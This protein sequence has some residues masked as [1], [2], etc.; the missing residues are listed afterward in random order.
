MTAGK[1][2]HLSCLS[3]GVGEEQRKYSHFGHNKIN[4]YLEP[5]DYFNWVEKSKKDFQLSSLRNPPKLP[6]IKHPI[7]I[8]KHNNNASAVPIANKEIILPKTFTTRKGALLL[9]SEDLAN[10]NRRWD[11]VCLKED[12]GQLSI[13]IEEQEEKQNREPLDVDRR[14]VDEF[15][16]SI[17][18]FG[19]QQRNHNYVQLLTNID[20]L[21]RQFR[22]GFSAKRYLSTWSKYWDHSTLDKL[23]KDGHIQNKSLFQMARLSSFQS[24]SL[25]DL[26]SQPLPYRLVHNML[27]TNLRGYTFLR[28]INNQD[29]N[30]EHG[31][32]HQPHGELKVFDPPGSTNN[33]KDSQEILY[34]QLDRFHQ[35]QVLTDY[36]LQSTVHHAFKVRQLQSLLDTKGRQPVIELPTL[37]PNEV[38]SCNNFD[39]EVKFQRQKDLQVHFRK[40][41]RGKKVVLPPLI[42]VAAEPNAGLATSPPSSPKETGKNPE[43][44][45]FF[46]TITQK[47]EQLEL[48]Q[49]A[50]IYRKQM[51]PSNLALMNVTP[52]SSTNAVDPEK[53]FVNSG[54]RLPLM[55]IV[56][57]EPPTRQNSTKSPTI[58]LKNAEHQKDSK[59]SDG[60]NYLGVSSIRNRISPTSQSWDH[61][62]PT[63]E[64]PKSKETTEPTDLNPVKIIE[65]TVFSSFDL[66]PTPN[67]SVK[68]LKSSSQ[69]TGT[70]KVQHNQQKRA[71]RK[72]FVNVPDV[73]GSIIQA[74]GGEIVHVGGSLAQKKN[75]LPEIPPTGKISEKIENE[76]KKQQS[77]QSTRKM[78]VPGISNHFPTPLTEKVENGIRC[79][80]RNLSDHKEESRTSMLDAPKVVEL[81]TKNAQRMASF[82]LDQD[83]TGKDLD[84]DIKMITR[85]VSRVLSEKNGVSLHDDYQTRIHSAENNYNQA[86]DESDTTKMLVSLEVTHQQPSYEMTDEEAMESVF[87]SHSLKGSRSG[88]SQLI[89]QKMDGHAISD[90]LGELKPDHL[91]KTVRR[92]STQLTSPT[93]PNRG[94]TVHTEIRDMGV[95]IIQPLKVEE[96]KST[97]GIERPMTSNQMTPRDSRNQ[98]ANCKSKE[99]REHKLDEDIPSSEFVEK[100]PSKSRI[101]SPNSA[102]PS[103]GVL[104]PS[105]KMKRLE[106]ESKMETTA[107][108]DEVSHALTRD[109]INKNIVVKMPEMF[110]THEHDQMTSIEGSLCHTA[111]VST[112]V[113]TG[114]TMEPYQ[115]IIGSTCT[116]PEMAEDSDRK[117]PSS[118]HPIL[119]SVES[120]PF[121]SN[122]GKRSTAGRDTSSNDANSNLVPK[123]KKARNASKEEFKVGRV[124]YVG[125]LKK[126]YSRTEI[127]H[128]KIADT[129]QIKKKERKTVKTKAKSLKKPK[130]PKKPKKKKN[131]LI[132][133]NVDR[134]QGSEDR[135]TGQQESQEQ[136]LA[137]GMDE[138]GKQDA[139]NL[140]QP[141]S[142]QSKNGVE[143]DE[144]CNLN[145]DADEKVACDI[146]DNKKGHN[147]ELSDP[148]V[149]EAEEKVKYKDEEKCVPEEQL[150][151]TTAIEEQQKIIMELKRILTPRENEP[152]EA[153][154]VT[155]TRPTEVAPYGMISNQ[156]ARAAERRARAAKRREQVEQKRK[157][158]EEQ[159]RREKEIAE[160]QEKMRLEL[161]EQRRLAEEERRLRRQEQEE[162]R[163]R[164]EEEELAREL[165]RLQALEAEKRRKEEHLRKLRQLKMIQAE[166]ER[167]R[168][169]LL[170]LQEKE[171]EERR[172]A[173]EE[174]LAQ[175]AEQ[176]RIEYERKRQEEEE[177]RMREEEE[178]RIR[179]EAEARHRM[180]EA[181]RMAEEKA[182]RAAEMEARFQF[183]QTLQAE[184]IGLTRCQAVTRA[185]VF[186]Y[187]E[188][189][190]V[191]GVD[192]TDQQQTTILGESP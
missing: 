45:R 38:H 95:A 56:N 147:S 36:L 152:K 124:D 132:K 158:R 116:N 74:P 162:E 10:K 14:T 90:Q 84:D 187:F 61:K 42:Q 140:H 35:E 86:H 139:E 156:E 12:N 80:S 138:S 137:S 103:S 97:A 149:S 18:A 2:L 172:K 174:M 67:E 93:T 114:Q 75:V 79:E 13:G 191:I 165:K 155:E 120:S 4:V 25:D 123:S 63:E 31:R 181:T 7:S 180:E 85:E 15:A 184:A 125:E 131:K 106:K 48:K 9:F 127:D 159:M 148:A 71:I 119:G 69:L 121:A 20:N 51:L 19:N 151:E 109:G 153:K 142:V 190:T 26:S 34:S 49:K 55:P 30:T 6:P 111:S 134:V 50:K 16:Q 47:P 108:G 104:H 52:V 130:M 115:E 182:K 113:D 136:T 27:Q 28:V 44:W 41:D 81:L 186:S 89:L 78:P 59:T 189:L 33:F 70:N 141:P 105:V 129:K 37:H 92:G 22:P 32:S 118:S 24:R 169:E 8:S 122:V 77:E 171:E 98:P 17:L 161:E 163:R 65:A 179:Q 40:H 21:H 83:G 154:E 185:F 112:D 73:K 107:F 1:T 76:L 170:K 176:E 39:S 60:T 57:I 166:E 87:V 46:P 188:L 101:S 94:N 82:I 177:Q 135:T 68:M 58:M 173:E 91:Y 3:R 145:E 168:Q 43:V 144:I 117:R 54:G 157:E 96:S 150:G 164:Q 167:K 146:T 64:S 100:K 23:L 102:A 29:S 62:T 66:N 5:Q 72:G 192:N 110:P 143:A 11:G 53:D 183:T 126:L 99:E 160:R 88:S 178:E 128:V 175:M 133:I